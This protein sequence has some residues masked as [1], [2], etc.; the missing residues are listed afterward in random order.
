MTL[1]KSCYL[2]PC[3]QSIYRTICRGAAS[4]KQLRTRIKVVQ[5]IKK[6]TQAMKMVAVAKLRA[7]Q[8]H[9]EIVRKF[10][11]AI[12]P[13]FEDVVTKPE[14]V[15]KRLVVVVTA[16][17]GLCGSVNSQ[18]S[19]KVRSMAK[20][21]D[22]K[23]ADY[24][25]ACLGEK[26]AKALERMFATNYTVCLTDLSKFKTPSFQQACLLAD[27]LYSQSFDQVEIV[28]NRFKNMIS[29]VNTTE[30]GFSFNTLNLQGIQSSLKDFE[31]D[32]DGHR[33]MLRNLHEFR[34]AVR[35]YHILQENATSEQSSRMNAMGG[36]SKNAEAVIGNLQLL[37]NRTRQA[38]ITTELMEIV[39]GAEATRQLAAASD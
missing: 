9:L 6:I 33:D 7:V 10:Q 19:R 39:S 31:I 23:N 37:Y 30:V 12:T 36:S 21:M 4:E 16:D 26:G 22:A 20:E 15:K 32:E 24:S 11:T 38:K 5:N 17:R 29:F 14:D 27:H 1:P 25:I 3:R 35:I 2:H 28:Y 8:S 34:F 18:T 13:L